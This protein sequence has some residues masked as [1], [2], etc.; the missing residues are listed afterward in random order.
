MKGQMR[1]TILSISDEVELISERLIS[2]VENDKT[3]RE[4][5]RCALHMCTSTF[6]CFHSAWFSNSHSDLLTMRSKKSTAIEAKP[7]EKQMELF[8][9]IIWWH[10]LSVLC[11]IVSIENEIFWRE[12]YQVRWISQPNCNKTNIANRAKCVSHFQEQN[13]ERD[14]DSVAAP[15]T[16]VAAAAAVHGV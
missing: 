13:N 16:A 2:S 4:R 9:F 10:Q 7:K 1:Y 11:L 5:R 15:V 14:A 3:K 8:N 12:N 6:L